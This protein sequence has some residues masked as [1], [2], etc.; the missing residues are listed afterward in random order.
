[1]LARGH[2]L[3]VGQVGMVGY[4]AD[5][6][7]PRI[8]LDVGED[9]VFFNNPDL[10]LTRSEMAL[11]L[12]ARGQVIGV[13]DVQSIE[14]SA[15]TNEDIETLQVMADQ[16]ALA[17]D[18]A[19]LL[20]ESRDAL[21]ELQVLYG[22]QTRQVWREHLNRGVLSSAYS[23]TGLTSGGERSFE[24][25]N[26]SPLTSPVL[27]EKEG[28]YE[29][30]VPLI[31]R[32]QVLGSLTLRRETDQKPWTQDDLR[33]AT[34]LIA[35]VLPALE[36]ARLLEKIQEQAQMESLIGQVSSRIQSSLDLETVLKTAVQEIGLAVNA[37]RVQIRLE[38]NGEEGN[39]PDQVN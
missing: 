38:K 15:F 4:V 11:P 23:R 32:G 24:D 10:P 18:N 26:I 6:G 9:A 31:L 5:V 21:E 30:L 20:K 17:L 29:M 34:D 2:K 36:N 27:R 13:L 33:L 16:I 12:K 3:R 14:E 37:S 7:V 8:A 25:I 35:Q 39:L 19:Q 28:K 1:M 22:Q